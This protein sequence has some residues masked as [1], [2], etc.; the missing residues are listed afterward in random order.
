[1]MASQ[2]V[3][4]YRAYCV[5]DLTYRFYYG[6]PYCNKFMAMFVITCIMGLISMVYPALGF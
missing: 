6:I 2:V 4:H 1:M 5:D 3:P